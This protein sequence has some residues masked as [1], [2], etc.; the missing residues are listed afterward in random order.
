M[1]IRDEGCPAAP[2]NGKDERQRACRIRSPDQSEGKQ[3]D[4]ALGQRDRD[5]RPDIVVGLQ[6]QAETGQQQQDEAAKDEAEEPAAA[7]NTPTSRRRIA[8]V[9]AAA[10]PPVAGPPSSPISRRSDAI[11]STSYQT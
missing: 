4:H 2:S 10:Y 5:K 8:A 3:V 7:H 6:K 11:S 9:W 1:M